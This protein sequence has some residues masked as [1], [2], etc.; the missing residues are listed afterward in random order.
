MKNLSILT[1]L[2]ILLVSCAPASTTVPVSTATNTPM[3]TATFTQEPTATFTPKPTKTL[4][5]T[6][7]PPTPTPT[8]PPKP[9]KTPMPIIYVTLGSPF[10]SECGDG[11]PRIW[12]NDS[13]NAAG[14]HQFDDHHGHVDIFVPKGCNVNKYSL[15]VLAIADGTVRQYSIGNNEY[16]Y[17][18]TLPSNVYLA[19]IE[20]AF[21]FAGVENFKLS[22]VTKIRLGLGHLQNVTIGQVKKGQPFADILPCCGHQKLAYQ[23]QIMY[24]GMEYMFTPTLF[25]QDPPD[26]V[27]VPGSPYDCEPELKDYAK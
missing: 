3:P 27:C 14:E 26:W 8:S 25:T 12:S 5:A 9:T 11:I 17:D 4:T 20:N 15:E 23:V 16:G 18:I 7:K 10:I 21:K 6:P 13:F 22:G 19:G 1:L 24:F 2:A